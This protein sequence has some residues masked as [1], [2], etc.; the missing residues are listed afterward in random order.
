VR[1]G[2]EVCD[3]FDTCASG[4]SAPG[5]KE[6]GILL[7]LGNGLESLLGKLGDIVS[8]SRRCEC[9]NSPLGD[10]CFEV[11][12]SNDLNCSGCS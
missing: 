12:S 9:C 1:V 10:G 3:V 4:E 2:V 6:P 11:L 8:G 7:T 5:T